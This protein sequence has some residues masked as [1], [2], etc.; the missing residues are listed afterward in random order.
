M[1]NAVGKVAYWLVLTLPV[2]LALVFS[3]AFSA[4]FSAPKSAVLGLASFVL[5]ALAL[6]FESRWK[7]PRE[8]WPLW[9]A[10]A[11]FAGI[12][13]VSAVR[14][15]GPLVCFES[16][17]LPV[18]GV[19]LFAASLAAL[20]GENSARKTRNLQIAISL[21]AVLVSV[22]AV[23]QFFGLNMPG[24]LRPLESASNR[25][26]IFSTLGNPDFVAVFLAVAIPAAI[27]L[28]V[29]AR[30][31]RTRRAWVGISACAL[32][33]VAIVLTG[34]RGGVLAGAVGVSVAAIALKVK[35]GPILIGVGLAC[36]L[37]A[38]THLNTRTPWE[39]LRGRTFIWQVTL[40]ER[41]VG[42]GPG[43]FAY[44]YP[45][46]LGRF[47]SEPGH[48]ALLHFAGR[49]LHAQNDFVEAW[50]DTGWLGAGSLLLLLGAWFRIA[51]R[52]L[53]AADAATGPAIAA[54][55]ASVSA[56]C[57]ATL[58]D[59]PMHR[60][61]TLALLWLS[62]AVPLASPT[63]PL[64]LRGRARWLSYAGAAGLV[65][66]GSYL[67]F[68]PLAA[69]YEIAKGEFDENAEQLDSS[70]LAYRAALR[71]EPSSPDANYD[72]VRALAKSGDY[73]DALA[74]SR[75]TVRYVDEPELYLLRSRIL[76]NAG[77]NIEAR[78]ELEEAE[79]RFPYAKQVHAEIASLPPPGTE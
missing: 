9:I 64:A 51:I 70:Q 67:C 24:A 12:T 34:S 55:I 68:A 43:S 66:I 20:S 49:E 13:L 57:V 3:S 72:L 75:I 73:P 74:Q 45:A 36:A 35:R 5:G 46:R 27:G 39:S 31:G 77:R 30:R 1:N 14:S 69:S 25:M 28:S 32:I 61:E 50:H 8:E 60:A 18:C 33:G 79:R 23:A 16:V 38:G 40:D 71:W 19:L 29:A 59:F 56:L 76:Q 2:I 52:R 37:A 78:R 11:S 10:A 4:S 42:S 7:R 63:V 26:R 6:I 48:N 54:A 44:A 53:R 62:M 65:V 58:F 17:E 21:A 47:F 41:A 22:V 15:Q